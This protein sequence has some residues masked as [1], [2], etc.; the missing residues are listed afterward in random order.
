MTLRAGNRTRITLVL[1]DCQGKRMDSLLFHNRSQDSREWLRQRGRAASVAVKQV[2]P[3][4]VIATPSDDLA[5]EL[6]EQYHVDEPSIDLDGRY[7]SGA[8]DTRID[9]TGNF[10]YGQRLDGDPTYTDGTEVE[11]HVPATGAQ[12]LF[13][14]TASTHSMNPPRG[15]FEHGEL[16]VTFRVPSHNLRAK[17]SSSG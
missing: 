3:D 10:R 11:V 5:R 14:L 6:F 15:R 4:R 17:Q 9:V 1:F 7:M 2:D 16:V 13:Q 8:R 12:E